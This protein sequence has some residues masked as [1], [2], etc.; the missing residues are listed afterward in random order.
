[1]PILGIS[2]VKHYYNPR[3]VF[4]QRQFQSMLKGIKASLIRNVFSPCNVFCS[5]YDSTIDLSSIETKLSLLQVGK[6]FVT[7]KQKIDSEDF[8]G[9][10]TDLESIIK[11]K[12]SAGDL[13]ESNETIQMMNMLAKAYV[14]TNQSLEA[15]NLYVRMFCYL[16]KQLMDYGGNHVGLRQPYLSKNEDVDF[17][18]LMNLIN[19]IMDNLILLIQ[20][21]KPESMFKI[22]C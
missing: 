14:K 13:N 15:W 6:L 22:I 7:A 4:H 18:K 3:Q 12:L 5:M 1:M 9:V 2:N 11:P 19:S 20:Q 8:E 16:M 10:I 21:D 17:F